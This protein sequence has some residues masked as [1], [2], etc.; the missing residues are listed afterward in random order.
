M[1]DAGVEILH[2]LVSLIYGHEETGIVSVS[3]A[4]TRI[5]GTQSTIHHIHNGKV[6]ETMY[7]NI[8]AMLII[9]NW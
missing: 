3:T 5:Y 6:G 7:S 9:L 8:D 4:A 1:H 2:I